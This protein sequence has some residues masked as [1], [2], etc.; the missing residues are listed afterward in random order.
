MNPNKEELYLDIS[1]K[2][3]RHPGIVYLREKGVWKGYCQICLK[4]RKTTAHHIIP[5]RFRNTSNRIRHVRIRVCKGCDIK[6]HPENG[7]K[8]NVILS[9]QK[10]RILQLETIIKHKLDYV[11][12]TLA[13]FFHQR[14]S[15]LFKELKNIPERF[16]ST[17]KEIQY[18]ITLQV[19][20]LREWKH[21]Q[22]KIIKLVKRI[23]TKGRKEKK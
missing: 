10:R 15:D 18:N 19:G 1:K 21:L 23:L 13:A 20:R 12:P 11:L 2:G 6:L 3:K 16:K 4:R 17:P 22:S 14:G 9:N 8:E 7:S 5:K